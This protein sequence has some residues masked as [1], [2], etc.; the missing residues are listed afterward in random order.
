MTTVSHSAPERTRSP[1]II[2]T[3]IIAVPIAL[4]LLCLAARL[5]RKSVV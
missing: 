3:L 4:A 1:A 5:D 2:A